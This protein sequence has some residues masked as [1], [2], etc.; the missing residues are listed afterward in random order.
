MQSVAGGPL[1]PVETTMEEEYHDALAAAAAE[2]Q[3]R[4]RAHEEIA[5]LRALL[6]D[7]RAE[8]ATAT[9]AGA[10]TIIAEIDRLETP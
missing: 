10:L 4:R 8:L 1:E 2:A 7:A 3:E 5:M 6:R 9:S